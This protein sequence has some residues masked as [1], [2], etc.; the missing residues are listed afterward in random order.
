MIMQEESP[1]YAARPTSSIDNGTILEPKSSLS[2]TP[3]RSHDGGDV[4]TGVDAVDCSE[5]EAEASSDVDAPSTLLRAVI[6]RRR[7]IIATALTVFLNIFLE[8]QREPIL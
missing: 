2:K 1:S 6:L 7:L 5:I 8:R 4:T 3:F